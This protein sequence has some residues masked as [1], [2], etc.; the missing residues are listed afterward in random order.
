M[1]TP[2]ERG[3][4]FNINK[5]WNDIAEQK[6]APMWFLRKSKNFIGSGGGNRSVKLGKKT[7][8]VQINS[9]AYFIDGNTVNV[10]L[11]KVPELSR[12][13]GSAAIVND[14]EQ[15]YLIVARTD[16][17]EFVV[18]TSQCTH[19]YKPLVYDH[20]TKLFRCASRK[21]EFRLD[22]SV[23]K[24]TAEKPLRIYNSHLQQGNLI[25]D[26]SN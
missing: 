23:M 5:R 1:C 21:S 13:G 6:G 4:Q 24:G 10:M 9:S 25:V 11:E 7:P 12:V 18:A 15:I 19:R 20:D 3:T 2:N 14:V 17:N 22:G 8:K 26:V 16:E